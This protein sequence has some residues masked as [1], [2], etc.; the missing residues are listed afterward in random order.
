MPRTE[1]RDPK[2]FRPFIDSF[3]LHLESL[4]R[5]KKTRE[6]YTDAAAWFGG[7]MVEHHPKVNSWHKVDKVH[8]RQ[9]FAWLN[10]LE[11]TPRYCNQVGR[12]LQAF[13]KWFAAE[14]DVPNPMDLVKP[15][16]APKLGDNPPPVIAQEQLAALVKDAERGRDFES[17]RDAALLRMFAS[18]GA[19]LAEITNLDIADLDLSQRELTVTGK[20]RKVRKAKFDAKTAVALDRYLRLRASRPVVVELG[21]TGLWIAV[22]SRK[23]MTPNG[24]RQILYRRAERL[25]I[26]LH[27]HLFRHTFAH[28][29]LLNG[30][31]EGDLVELV[32]W[33]SNQMLALYG[34]SGRS[35]RARRNYDNVNVMGG[36]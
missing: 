4:R 24:V 15:P 26:K 33:E 30:G 36:I 13:W 19:R 14:E 22:R 27:P 11:Y 18:T 28:N 3:D 25:G 1:R 16:A 6:I 23:P 5:S 31:A 35:A 8:L 2:H 21:V 17:R 34:R 12:S 7:W 9:F 32:G 20:A 10:G 29:F